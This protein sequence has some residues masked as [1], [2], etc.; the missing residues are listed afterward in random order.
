MQPKNVFSVPWE[1][2]VTICYVK[3]LIDINK[4]E[5]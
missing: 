3:H 2:S 1:I 5:E 4:Y